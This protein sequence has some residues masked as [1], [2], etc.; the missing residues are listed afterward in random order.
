MPITKSGAEL[1]KYAMTRWRILFQL[2]SKANQRRI[3]QSGIMKSQRS[4]LLGMQRGNQNIRD[5]LGYTSVDP[6]NIT[7]DQLEAHKLKTLDSMMKSHQVN[8]VRWARDAQVRD[9]LDM[10]APGKSPRLA[11]PENSPNDIS[12]ISADIKHRLLNI[13]NYSFPE[14]MEFNSPFVGPGQKFIVKPPK[15]LL[16][17]KNKAFLDAFL[18]RH[19]LYEAQASE[20]AIQKA[21]Q[22]GMQGTPRPLKSFT[23]YPG[24]LKSSQTGQEYTNHTDLNVLVKERRDLDTFTHTNNP[25]YKFVRKMREAV[26]R[27]YMDAAGGFNPAKAFQP[28]KPVDMFKSHES[29]FLKNSKNPVQVGNDTIR[30]GW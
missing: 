27:P 30:T 6:A 23:R 28:G 15:K 9:D 1:V 12:N 20:K 11:V 10:L 29:T 4:K 25:A 14:T 7:Y 5:R 21:I 26:E 2:L 8:P 16:K 3:Q 13:H 19:E 22:R 18:E 17:P 24:K